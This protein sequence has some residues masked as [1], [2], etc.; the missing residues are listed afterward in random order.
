MHF[1]STFP[2]V[3]VELSLSF[4]CL[5]DL[6]KASRACKVTKECSQRV[7]ERVT[8]LTVPFFPPCQWRVM[9]EHQPDSLFNVLMR[10]PALQTIRLVKQDGFQEIVWNMTS[11][12]HVSLHH[13]LHHLHE[14][15]ISACHVLW[16]QCCVLNC[17]PG[18]TKSMSC[19]RRIL[20]GLIHPALIWR[21]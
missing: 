12:Q 7:L 10:L 19:R 17:V 8:D 9:N 13:H 14:P 11:E 3:L 18:A 2:T 20:Y 4:L 1:F 21:R 15:F 5:S 6:L 16:I